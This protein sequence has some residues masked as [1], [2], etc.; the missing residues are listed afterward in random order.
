MNHRT[1]L[2]RTLLAGAGL[3]AVLGGCAAVDRAPIK[4][5]FAAKTIMELKAELD[6]GRA[7]SVALVQGY[8]ARIDELDRRGPTLRAVLATNP[9]AL[10]QAR[11]LDRERAQGN[12]RGPLHGIPILLKDNIETLDVMPTTAG[13]LALARNFAQVDAPIVA[14]LRAAGAIVLGKT[15]LSEWANFRSDRSISGWSA[16]GGL[17]RNPH[18]LDRSPCGSSAGSGVAMSAGFAAAAVG[19]ETDGSITCPA[20]MNGVVGLKPTLGLLAQAG[21]VPIAHS[22]DT[23][24][25]MT[26][27]VTDTAVMLTAMVG[28]V[29]HNCSALPG[30][31]RKID[32]ASLISANALRGKRV[33]VWRFRAG[34][35]P[36]VDA[37]YERALQVLRDAGATLIEVQTPENP[38]IRGAEDLV[39]LTEFKTELNRYLRKTP[40]TVAVKDLKQLMEFNA[41]TPRELALFG[42]EV[43]ARANAAKNLDDAAYLSAV[44]DAKRLAGPDGIGKQLLSEQFDFIVAPTNGPS[45]RVDIVVGDQF[46]GSFSTL[47]AVSGYPHLT[48]PMGAIQGLPVGLSFIGAPWTEGALL[49]AGFAF[50][51][52]ARA[53]K[54]PAFKATIE[55]DEVA[56]LN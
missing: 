22:Q 27:T 56:A 26:R 24:G 47:P 18:V 30:D 34:R 44:A 43:L 21:I 53:F 38:R 50:E 33:G 32:Y 5:A 54:H 45:W 19:T 49:A 36:A 3:W 39:L 9:D 15:N 2:I 4:P 42:Q 14:N 40:A 17:T 13:S 29:P 31:C 35:F 25:P 7:T 8:L 37:V 46:S 41:A 55:V 20:S 11:E 48:V 6:A 28:D 51:Q 16:V 1:A 52:R 10:Q 23:A 12:L